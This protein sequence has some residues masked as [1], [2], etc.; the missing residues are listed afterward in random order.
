MNKK[1]ILSCLLVIGFLVSACGQAATPTPTA[2]PT[3]TALPAVVETATPTQ[4][5]A[6]TDTPLPTNTPL[7]P[8]ETPIPSVT[9][10]FSPDVVTLAPGE[11]IVIGYLLAENTPFGVDSKR[12]VELAIE[13][14]GG[15]I[16]G[17][18]IQLVGYNEEC[19]KLAAQ[20]G[21][22]ILA[23]DPKVLAVI[24][25]SCSMGA[26]VAAKVLSD[27][28]KVLLSPSNSLPDLTLPETHQP[29]YLRVTPNDQAQIV[30]AAQFAFEKLGLRSA[31][32]VYTSNNKVRESFARHACD[33]FTQA[34]GQCVAE[35]AIQPGTTYI[36][37]ALNFFAESKPEVI[38]SFLDN[39][40]SALIAKEMKNVAG[41]ENAR[42]ILWEGNF[43]PDFLQ[44]AGESA[45][46]VF[47]TQ[48]N[49][50]NPP[51]PSLDEFLLKYR[52][53]YNEAPQ[54]PYHT[55]A[56]DAAMLLLSTIE[57][58]AVQGGD[59]SL[60]IDLQAI[61]AG[62]FS[63]VGF[64]GLTGVLTC[65]PLG[66]CATGGFGIVFEYVSGD[67]STFNPGPAESLASN[68]RRVWP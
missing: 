5:P 25:T 1:N 8:T 61:S 47:V 44:W 43:N 68:P 67:P 31:A 33:A 19:N 65:T 46:G 10:T 64:H 18:P 21:A 34:G 26:D 66:D 29:L 41:L 40:E 23:L 38:F 22:Q 60:M 16:L 53:R 59:G 57:R 58:V 30:T 32:L 50:D 13:E 55:F 4:P 51:S 48:L 6:P 63:T 39:P 7:P 3:P 14:L 45:V 37:P 62:L 54:S 12:G 35:R 49:L 36:I 42:L 9:P 20:R 28:A 2:P 24:G 27:K 56:Y 17:H 11:P 52:T 15:Q